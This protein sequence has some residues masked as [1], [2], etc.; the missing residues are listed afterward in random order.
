MKLLVDMNLSPRRVEMLAD[1]GFEA[2]HWS[3]C[4][5]NGHDNRDTPDHESHDR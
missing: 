1:A 2:A 4:G 5:A 3:A